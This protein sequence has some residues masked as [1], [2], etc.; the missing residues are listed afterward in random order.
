MAL[1]NSWGDW[2]TSDTSG[3][4]GPTSG[5]E[6]R[7]QVVFFA[8]AT[9][10]AYILWGNLSE[11]YYIQKY[12]INNSTNTLTYD[13]QGS[14][15]TTTYDIAFNS[16]TIVELP[17]FNKAVFVNNAKGMVIERN[18][19]TNDCS[20]ISEL[21]DIFDA[22]S[23]RRVLVNPDDNS[24]FV[25]FNSSNVLEF[26]TFNNSTNT[27]TV[28]ST[29]TLGETEN[30]AVIIDDNGTLR[31]AII[32][33]DG[34]KF[35]AST[36]D[37][38]GGNASTTEL[39]TT[40]YTSGQYSG[41]N[42]DYFVGD[43]T[44][45]LQN[46][47]TSL[48]IFGFK[49]VDNE[50]VESGGTTIS[51]ETGNNTNNIR[52]AGFVYSLPESGY[53]ACALHQNYN[54]TTNRQNY[55]GI[56]SMSDAGTISQVGDW[57]L[58]SDYEEIA[59]V[60]LM[61]ALNPT[62]DRLFYANDDKSTLSK[63][64]LF[65]GAEPSLPVR[66]RSAVSITAVGNAQVDTAQSKFGGAS[67]YF[68]GNNDYLSI[69]AGS[70]VD[71]T[72]TNLTIES[73]VRFSILPNS[74]T[75]SGG[76]YMM[77]T[78]ISSSTYVLIDDTA[79]SKMRVQVADSGTY[80]NFDS[81]TTAWATNTW[82]HIAIVRNSNQYDV[83]VDGVALT[84][85][86]TSVK[87]GG[88]YVNAVATTIG[89]FI[90]ARGSWYGW[91]DD[92]RISSSA[93]YTT[94]FTPP[95]A[96]HVNDDN[97]L[98]LL[99][100]DGTDGSTTFI[101]DKGSGRSAVG[102]SAI[103]NA[104]VD[105]AQSKFGGASAL[106]DGTGD[107]VKC[108]TPL[109]PATDDWTVEMWVYPTSIV[110]L[111]YFFAQYTSGSAGRS[112]FYHTNS[113]NVG[114]F[115]NG[116]PSITTTGTISTSSWQHIAWVRNGSSFKIYING[117]E[118]ASA[119]GSPSIQQINS[120]VGAQDSVGSNGFIGNIDEVRISSTARYTTGFTPPTTA[121]T[122]DAD[123]L[124][125]I[126]ADGTNGSTT[127]LDDNSYFESAPAGVTHEG[128]ADLTV[129]VTVTASAGVIKGTSAVLS[130]VF[131]PTIFAVASRNGSIDMAVQVDFASTANRFLSTDVT[132]ANLVNLSLQAARI[133]PA[134]SDLNVSFDAITAVS[135]TRDYSSSLAVSFEQ[136]TTATRIKQFDATLAG[137]FSPAIIAVASRNG[138][139][140]AAAQT[141]L[142]VT[143]LRIQQLDSALTVNANLNS[144]GGYLLE[145]TANIIV[146]TALTAN[147]IQYIIG[148]SVPAFRPLNLIDNPAQANLYSF[149]NSVYKGGSGSLFIDGT[150]GLGTLQL[151]VNN[152][153]DN[154]TTLDI[155][156]NQDFVFETWIRFDG[157]T[158]GVNSYDQPILTFEPLFGLW[159]RDNTNR[160][161][162]KLGNGFSTGSATGA[163]SFVYSVD[164]W[165]HISVS[166]TNNVLSY[167]I[168]GSTEYTTSDSKAYNRT[169]GDGDMTVNLY[170]PHRFIDGIY[171]DSMTY[172]VGD[173][174][175]T[176]L[177][178]PYIP[179]NTDNTKFL[180][181]FD[182]SNNLLFDN[183]D[184]ILYQGAA[185]LS[186]TALITADLGGTFGADADLNV[187]ITL[188][189]DVDKIIDASASVATEFSATATA[190]KIL[191]ADST[192]A[193][194][195]AQTV[196]ATRIRSGA[197]SLNSAFTQNVTASRTAGATT[198]QDT[199]VDLTAQPLNIKQ[200]AADLSAFVSTLT[201]AGKVGDFFVNADL[202]TT[203]AV[204]AQRTAD[205]QSI[206]T[207]NVTA[208]ATALRVQSSTA[209]LDTT[210]D[211]TATG[212][213][214]SGAIAN[215][216][217]TVD[218][219]AVGIRA[220]GLTAQLDSEFNATATGVTFK[221]TTTFEGVVTT[222]LE[223]S[224]EVT[225]T[226][227]AE[228]AVTATQTASGIKAI[229]GGATLN[230]VFSP[231]IIAVVN[232]VGEIDLSATTQLSTT[233][234][235][236]VSTTCTAPVTASLAVDA[237]VIKQGHQLLNIN[238][239]LTATVGG[240]FNLAAEFN[241]AFSAVAQG[242]IIHT[243]RYV[244]VVPRETRRFAIVAETR[245]H[246]IHQ[247]TRTITL[248]EQ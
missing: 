18:T 26:C 30:G 47:T 36:Y 31:I 20:I 124:L 50:W 14:G 153:N 63:A 11:T 189:A 195:F 150:G 115:I 157:P 6:P 206:Q 234:V 86:A 95:T 242:G 172:K 21:G 229:E 183:I 133:R 203:L 110:A 201:A 32:W 123:T 136:T 51:I 178:S 113:G 212:Q 140:D 144:N 92:F 135:R 127:F 184:N 190:D 1:L 56:F 69:P 80:M 237:G 97:T 89:R 162:L 55:V 8:G 70:G 79:T 37:F 39:T 12:N 243:D 38:D 84:R 230:G 244:Y 128:A 109:L 66:G 142:T 54:G 197:T 85:P 23:E 239:D 211:L 125:L 130:G 131:S 146:N 231:N 94:G 238:A 247:E 82:Y 5:G 218:L 96:P 83:Y 217:T 214:V 163:D 216:D 246:T 177:S 199:T 232:R 35:N 149:N 42:C 81:T 154:N 88:F 182:T 205:A 207:A 108:G 151:D 134:E 161:D 193:S 129:G 132:L 167:K 2:T 192:L 152:T 78:S 102:L 34:S 196:T 111:D 101:D 3:P 4:V 165:Y 241:G 202:Q 24:K 106:F 25:G 107:A 226:T 44:A 104:Q 236:T 235:K 99:H 155:A 76:S 137:V 103:G 33:Y 222:T 174:T 173:S 186:T 160:L 28:D 60:R 143:P 208:T 10:H 204:T 220:K 159:L 227:S 245:S 228:L 233:A 191:T 62:G 138:S 16:T 122:N 58:V 119:T 213:I 145:D 100:M 158:N 75:I 194:A 170:S 224:I 48:K 156:E 209:S 64:T 187:N 188:T 240:L 185:T 114:L 210:V 139:I 181:T 225:R 65:V 112:T 17:Q 176:G 164:V 72:A 179:N 13:S 27:V 57:K 43:T 147:A 121:F 98:L 22:G 223:S 248:G 116:G 41:K 169:L 77:L 67:G 219:T 117:T 166:R 71:D 59:N 198:S 46:D 53:F 105:T 29:V 74:Q 9:E 168:N 49:W 141:S 93:R 40:T 91:M 15:Y 221:G 45:L 120:V 52:T 200:I 126:H 68:D 180:Y 148:A 7:D 19:S 90:D 171:F 87:S 118:E 215:L 73:W 61:I 175:V